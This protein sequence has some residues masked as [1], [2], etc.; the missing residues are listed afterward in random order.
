M[1]EAENTPELAKYLEHIAASVNYVNQT[2]SLL[3]EA[4]RVRPKVY[5]APVARI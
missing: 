5:L 1:I 4:E 3:K 2:F